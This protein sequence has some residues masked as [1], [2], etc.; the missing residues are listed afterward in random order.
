VAAAADTDAGLA[1]RLA[2][3]LEAA[4]L[5]GRV[6]LRY[7]QTGVQPEWKAD[8]TPVTVADREAETEIR[9]CLGRWFPDDGLAGEEFPEK[10]SRSGF[11]WIIDPIDGTKSFV[12][13]VPLYGVLLALEGPEAVELGVVHMPALGETVWARRGAGSWWNGRRA[14]VSTVARL[15]DAC[16]CYTSSTSFLAQQR[17]EQWSRLTA[18]AR[19]VRGW[20]DCYGHLLVATG[21]AEASF[22]PA[23]KPWD[24]GPL[25]PILTEAGGTFTDWRGQATIYGPD[26]FSTNGALFGQILGE[27]Q[28]QRGGQ[29]PADQA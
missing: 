9:G 19:L 11:R 21:R 22:D 8:A 20:G 13:G 12:H 14:R 17:Q 7:F 24:C 23:M 3:A 18:K 15:E 16:L 26:A 6:T 4:Y 28:G 2:A 27:L 29:G 10:R 25:L 1:E 5:A